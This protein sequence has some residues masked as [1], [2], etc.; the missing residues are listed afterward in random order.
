MCRFLEF[1]TP[2]RRS[3]I[4]RRDEHQLRAAR[5]PRQLAPLHAFGGFVEEVRDSCNLLRA[6]R[7]L[8]K[9]QPQGEVEI[10]H[11]AN[12]LRCRTAAVARV[13]RCNAGKNLLDQPAVA[14]QNRLAFRCDRIELARP[15]GRLDANQPLLLQQRQGR[16][17]DTRTGRIGAAKAI[18]DRLDDFITVR[19]LFTDQFQDDQTHIA[20]AEETAAD[21]EEAEMP[22]L[23]AAAPGCT[24]ALRATM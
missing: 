11:R 9:A 16:I 1:C 19:G 15:V 3:T 4:L 10:F 18:L 17:D 21:A 7:A 20:L 12:D 13:D 24:F 22:T 14:F 6:E 5:L 23:A 8:R 2:L